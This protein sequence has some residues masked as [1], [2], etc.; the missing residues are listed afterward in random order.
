MFLNKLL[1]F[2]LE[3]T[4]KVL[5]IYYVGNYEIVQFR[6]YEEVFFI[7]YS[8][9]EQLD[10]FDILQK[11]DL[12]LIEIN[13]NYIDKIIRWI[14]NLCCKVKIPILAILNNCNNYNVPYKVDTT[15]ERDCLKC[16]LPLGE[17]IDV[18]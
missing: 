10:I 9:L 3:W 8:E 13:K 11:C 6:Y 16:Q 5:K 4:I 15:R 18:C 14:F 12:S 2:I 7:N 1:V 17:M